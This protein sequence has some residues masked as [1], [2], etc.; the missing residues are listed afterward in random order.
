MPEMFTETLAS[1]LKSKAK[2]NMSM[3]NVAEGAKEEMSFLEPRERSWCH[4][5]IQVVPWKE[6]SDQLDTRTGHKVTGP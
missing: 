6:N 4:L 2:P 3:Q 5:I 1:L